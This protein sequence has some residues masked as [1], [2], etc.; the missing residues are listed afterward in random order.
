M[1]TQ[2]INAR[3]KELYLQWIHGWNRRESATMCKAFDENGTLI[4]F[5]GSLVKGRIELEELLTE[6]F[7][8][9]ATAAYVTLVRDIQFLSDTVAVLRADVGMVPTGSD[10]INPVFN[11]VQIMTAKLTGDKWLIQFFQN[12]PAALHAQPEASKNLTIEL[13]NELQRLVSEL[14]NLPLN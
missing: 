7:T 9:H 10:N 3:V 13:M 11:A 14:P 2:D 5:D 8:H 4:G 12:T 6:V 1:N